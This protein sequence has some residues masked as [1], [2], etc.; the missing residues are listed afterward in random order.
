MKKI[1]KLF[2][3]VAAI[4]ALA[5]SCSEPKDEKGSQN[6]INETVVLTAGYDGTRTTLN[7]S[8]APLWET[9]DQLWV[10]DGTHLVSAA[11]AEADN[12]K[13]SA[14]FEFTGLTSGATEYVGAYAGKSASVAMP[15][16][17]TF[18]VTINNDG[19]WNDAH[20]AVGKASKGNIKL[21]NVSTAIAFRTEDATLGQVRIS[22]LIEDDEFPVI[23]NINMADTTIANVD[24][25][26][27]LVATV[28]GAGTYYVGFFP[29]DGISGLKLTLVY[30]NGNIKVIT[31]NGTF[32]FKG[33]NILDLGLIDGREGKT[34]NVVSKSPFET[35]SGTIAE[36]FTYTSYKGDAN[37]APAINGGVIRLY[38]P[39]SGKTIG[40]SIE[41]ASV[42][43]DK[44]TGLHLTVGNNTTVCIALDGADPVLADSLSLKYNKGLNLSNLDCEKVTVY[45]VHPNSNN[46]L[47]IK[48]IDV[49]YIPDARTPQTL[50]FPQA[51]Y[52]ATI[53]S[54]FVAPVLSG[55]QTT[56]TYESS[57]P[58]V[59]TVDP[60]TG[61]VTP[62]TAGVTTITATAA[63][64]QTYKKGTASYELTVAEASVGVAGI[65]AA[66]DHDTSTPFV[67]TL[68]N[69]IVTLV[70]EAYPY[71]VYIEEDGAGLYVYNAFGN[72]ASSLKVGD[73]ISGVVSGAGIRYNVATLEVTSLDVS[74]AT[75]TPDQALPLT[76]V[77]CAQLKANYA[78]YEYCHI[79][80]ENAT[81]SD[82]LSTSDRSGSIAQA[83]DTVAIYAQV[84]NTIAIDKGTTVD[85]IAWPVYYYNSGAQTT[86]NQLGI[87]AQSDITVKGGIGKI[88]MDATKNIAVGDTWTIG[89]TCNS[90][91]A[92]TYS[93]SNPA[94]ATVDPNTGV[95]TAVAVGETTI[96]ASAPAANNYT[97]AEATCVVTVVEG[98]SVVS[99]QYT[100]DTTDN[101]TQGSNNS[102]TGQCDVT[103]NGIT[104]NVTGN[105]QQHPWRIGGK[106]ITNTDRAVYTKTAISSNITK[107]EIIHGAASSITV[108]SLTVTVHSTAADAASGSNPVATFTPAFVEN[109]TVTVNKS[110]NTSWANC[111]YR[112]VYNVTVSGSSNKFVAFSGVKF[113]GL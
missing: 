76:T 51:A 41:I 75:I 3:A 73:K 11:V 83:E 108:N 20:V 102:Y 47:Y 84:A 63:A 36:G 68:T 33:N 49:T 62:L 28:S 91:A 112:F 7:E 57:E 34:Y 89:A 30:G 99:L 80:V 22:G 6:S 38:Q 46:R 40:G 54:A 90:G 72:Q 17:G 58:A 81:V 106:S 101:A 15:S 35:V 21:Y 14:S 16:A 50:S 27:E 59:A 71:T 5:S 18:K 48:A 42:G 55:A 94:A 109:G 67:A 74:A 95:V 79:K 1:F 44:I 86:T 12:G 10:S 8:F 56:V 103:Y 37:T 29:V 93:S 19:T 104:W 2:C 82:A 25:A 13:A 110:D 105:A 113:Y 65:K 70:Q 39:A 61:A 111:F 98:G 23:A 45:G 9:G 69:A 88:E 32:N 100:L 92:I 53:G 85:L 4:A 24:V 64:D 31:I 60:A 66:I 26:T 96:T 43:G 52:N 77:T 107:I 87:W 97:A 78:A